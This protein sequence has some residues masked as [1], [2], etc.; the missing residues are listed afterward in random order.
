M[1]PA[2]GNVDLY[3][4]PLGAGGHCVRWNGRTSE[5]LVARHERREPCDLYH[6]ALEVRLDTD[7]DAAL[8]PLQHAAQHVPPD[9]AEPIDRHSHSHRSAPSLIGFML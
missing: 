8:R 2:N 1:R 4:L 9:P 7:L 5:A 3:W 6:T